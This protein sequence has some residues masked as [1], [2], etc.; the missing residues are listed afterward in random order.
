M[1]K[2]QNVTEPIIN[3]MEIKK[4]RRSLRSRIKGLLYRMVGKD[5]KES[6]ENE[7]CMKN[8][9]FYNRLGGG[10]F[11]EVFLV[12]YKVDGELYAMKIL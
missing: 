9:V 10:A 11:G 3:Q 8:F 12:R 2:E 4:D 1:E 7:L 6:E 5:A